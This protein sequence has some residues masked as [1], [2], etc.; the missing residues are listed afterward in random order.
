MVRRFPERILALVLMNSRAEA[1]GPQAQEARN[2]MIRTV[3][4]DGT[5]PIADI[6]VP[7]LLAPESISTMPQVTERVHAMI[8]SAPP[9]GVI[10]ALKA[11]RDRADSSDLLETISV[12]TLVVAGREDQLMPVD[13]ARAMSKRIPGAHF[14]LIAGAGHLVPMEQPIPTSRVIAEF[15]DAIA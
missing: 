11:M 9:D 4:Q 5:T 8:K 1:D 12:P 14:T 15:L 6:L 10:G 13:H 3:E 7:K 2:E